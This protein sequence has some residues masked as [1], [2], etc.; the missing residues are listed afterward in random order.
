MITYLFKV[1]FILRILF[2]LPFSLEN[3]LQVEIANSLKALTTRSI[4]DG[5]AD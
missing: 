5:T 1:L 3:C 2:I 4:K